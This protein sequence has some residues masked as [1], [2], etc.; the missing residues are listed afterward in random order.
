[1]KNYTLVEERKYLIINRFYDFI[2][3][4]KFNSLKMDPFLFHLLINCI[5]I[6]NRII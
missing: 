2:S 3:E 4:Q 1:M 5:K 6:L